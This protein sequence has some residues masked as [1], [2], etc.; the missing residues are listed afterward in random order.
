MTAYLDKYGKPTDD[1]QN[2]GDFDNDA[3]MQKVND[4]IES[5]RPSIIETVIYDRDS[6]LTTLVSF[7]KSY[8]RKSK[9]FDGLTVDEWQKRLMLEIDAELIAYAERNI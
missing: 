3:H 9:K 2:A 8:S 6:I 4:Y 1:V 7:H 5:I